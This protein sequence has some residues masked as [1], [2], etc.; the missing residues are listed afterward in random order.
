LITILFF[1]LQMDTGNAMH[2]DHLPLVDAASI[3]YN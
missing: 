2:L 3:L 1:P